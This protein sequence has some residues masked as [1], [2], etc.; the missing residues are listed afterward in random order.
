MQA[1]RILV[2]ACAS[3]AS[4]VLS[5][6]GSEEPALDASSKGHPLLGKQAPEVD[7]E[8]VGGVGP[9]TLA[10]AR[11]KV[12]ILDFW[13]TYCGPCKQSFPKYQEIVDRYAGDVAVLAVSIDD[14]EQVQKDQLVAFANE[15]HA[16][17]AIT[18]DKGHK[19][20]KTYGLDALTMPTSFVIDKSGTV[21]HL[22]VGFKPGEEM[23][24]NDEVKALLP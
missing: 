4:L 17:F 22:H 13:G 21:R 6:G 9:K 23:K 20:A 11:G 10:A 3:L 16:K 7:A 8:V 2:V 24:I 14:P 5:C 1:N 18:W 12:V 19:A 15:T